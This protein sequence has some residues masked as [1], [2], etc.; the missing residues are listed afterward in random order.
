VK[1][2]THIDRQDQTTEDHTWAPHEELLGHD[3]SYERYQVS[4]WMAIVHHASK[5][6]LTQ[7]SINSNKM[8]N[9][10]KNQKIETDQK[11][12]LVGSYSKHHQNGQ[13]MRISTIG[14]QNL[15]I[16]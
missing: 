8:V 12:M 5:I 9:E 1:C 6:F 14:V 7:P 2:P 15:D 3:Q 4:R 11:H 13:N 16:L 10:A